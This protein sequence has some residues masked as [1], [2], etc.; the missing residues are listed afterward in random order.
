MKKNREILFPVGDE[1]RLRFRKMKLTVLLTFLVIATFGSG[2]S[3]VTLSLHFDKAHIQEVLGSI[4]KKTDYIFMYKDNIIDGSKSI[5]VDFQ[6][7][8]FEEVLKSICEQC[9]IDYEVRDR[10]IILKEKA[11]IR[12]SSVLQQPQ[13]KEISGSVKDAKGL[14]LPGVSVVVKG[15]TTGTVTDSDGK[16]TLIVPLDAKIIA[17]SFVGMKIQEILIFDKNLVNVVMEEEATALDE[18]VAIGYGTMKKSDLTGSVARANLEIFQEQPSISIIKSLQG[19][20]PGV[21]VGITTLAGQDPSILIRGVKTISGTSSPLIVLD[22][23]IYRGSLVDIN[24]DDVE[25]IDVLKDA[26]SA[27]IYGS[28]AANG[29]ILITTKKGA[30]NV[31]PMINYSSYYSVGTPTNTNLTFLK[32]D[33][34]LT[35]VRDFYWK[36]AYLAPNYTAINPGWDPNN[37][38][39]DAIV[40]AGY[41]NGIV[42]DWANVLTQSSQIKNHNLSI[43][44][45][46]LNTSYFIS[47]GFSK[48]E[49]LVINDNFSKWNVRIN[50]ENKINDW[51]AI[52][53]QTFFSSDDYSGSSPNY[54]F[55]YLFSPAVAYK[56]ENG[57]LI[58][59]MQ[60]PYTNPLHAKDIDD[61]D[62]RINLF[63]N[64]NATV[65]IPFVKG[66]KYK[67]NYSHNYRTRRY[68]MYDSWGN[69]NT[70]AAVK[71]YSTDYDQTIDNIISYDRTYNDIHKVSATLVYGRETRE[72]EFTDASSGEF[73]SF[74]L[75][76]NSL[77]GGSIAKQ[78]TSSDAWKENSLYS[79]GRLFYGYNNKYLTTLTIRRDGFSGFGTNKKFGVFPTAAVA[80][81]LSQ[82]NFIKQINWISNLKLRTSYGKSGNRTVT[83]Y[84]TLAKVTKT[85]TYSYGNGASPEEGQYISSLANNDLGWETTTGL[86]F[87]IDF[88]FLDNRIRGNLE[89]YNT[90]TKDV[91]YSVGI[92]VLTGFS[93][94]LT[95]IGQINNHGFE[96]LIS[97]TN[98]KRNGFE[99]NSDFSFSLARDKVVTILGI[100]ANGDGKE[101]D[102]VSS[103]IFIGKPLGTNYDYTYSGIYQIGDKIP[104]G[105]YAGSYKIVDLDK[106][107]AIT[108]KDRSI[109]GYRQPA[110]SFSIN[111]E[112]RY[113]EWSLVVFLNSIQG[114]KNRYMQSN[115]PYLNG[116]FQAGG[117]NWN[118]PNQ[119]DY[120]S[121]SNPNAEYP[122]IYNPAAI[123]PA[124]YRDRSFV[125]L[126]N[127]SLSYSFNRKILEK[128]KLSNLKLYVSGKN[129]Y[130]WTKW[131][132]WD[133]E[134]GYGLTV[135]GT[136]ITA[137]YTIGLNLSF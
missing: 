108:P 48:Q 73:S 75:S 58:R 92:P 90:K 96:M 135:G 40:K 23:I 5:S 65:D 117:A 126:Q 12:I 71:D 102:L 97:S 49:E 16:F 26:S 1:M 50:L 106:D 15:T 93:S 30:S 68:F 8:K 84:S 38:F 6:D 28:Q 81:V 61:F 121:P 131:K 33:K 95:N 80:W 66:L 14:P 4:E 94:S 124:T 27:A 101:D 113:K 104:S 18:V 42:T 2:F 103:G 118:I 122:A 123:T 125:R 129:L 114:G 77:E 51:L 62:K 60:S 32:K 88:G 67:L 91:L 36:D 44:G 136:P 52:G 20:I 85:K 76:Y 53:V 59:D 79:M 46:S 132:G 63:A 47:C 35:K 120:W 17:F 133:P 72:N 39:Q 34:Y 110:Y 10:Q 21:N 31:K 45:K 41:V 98:I 99:W 3:Q 100:D 127:V 137:N 43:T 109:T 7:A 29:V 56:N 130:T 78:L 87:G 83:R 57:D 119:W 13:K 54:G 82:E 64:F 74:G 22:G 107:G 55:A 19:V 69:S 11:D 24:K 134:A 111:N 25:A 112:F 9:N 70:G 115:S 86:N 128:L 116:A 105:Y 89:Y 37:Y